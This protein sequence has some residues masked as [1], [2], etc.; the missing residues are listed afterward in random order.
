MSKRKSSDE[1]R[2]DCAAAKRPKQQAKQHLYLLVDDWER[3]YSVRKLDVDAF[4]P[5]TE[6]TDLP[7]PE[8][9]LLYL[10]PFFTSVAGKLFL[11]TDAHAEALDDPPPYD[12]K[13][14]W[15]WTTTIKARPPFY[16]GRVLC[17]ALHP[18]GR[19]VFVSAGSRQRRRSRDEHS[20][21]QGQGTFSFD[22][23][24]LRWTR[25][26]DWVLP[27]TG[28]AYFDAE[29]DAWVGLCGEKGEG[30]GRL[31]TCDVVAPVAAAEFTS[32]PAWKLGEDKLFRN[33]PQL[34][35]GANLLYMGGDSKFCLVES[36]LHEA[37]E[38]D[39]ARDDLMACVVDVQCRPRPRRRVLR[40]TTFGLKYSKKGELQTKMRRTG[41]CKVY[42]R[43]HDFGESLA[44]WAFWL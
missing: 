21:E 28:Q 19:T 29:L 34:H 38:K 3:G 35:L 24:R 40:I 4:E 23:E 41:A 15:S 26:G 10:N 18:D 13:A 22:A 9:R 44:P 42:K 39:L 30:A 8:Q 1:S 17:H 12:S 33:G 31:C 2:G 20:P 5:A 36:L 6:H 7:P 37:D 27:F 11:F 43:P 14:A 25:H 32:A 16:T